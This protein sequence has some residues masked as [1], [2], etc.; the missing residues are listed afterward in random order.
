MIAWTV[1][2]DVRTLVGAVRLPGDVGAEAVITLNAELFRTERFAS[3]KHA[4]AWLD[5]RRRD[6]LARGWAHAGS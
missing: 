6:P 5:D 2:K 3:R 1:T 4:E